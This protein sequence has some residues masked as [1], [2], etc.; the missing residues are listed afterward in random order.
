MTYILII[1]YS[2]K[3]IFFMIKICNLFMLTKTFF[4]TKKSNIIKYNI[5]TYII[6]SDILFLDTT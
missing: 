5:L 1:K 6:N 2:K 3:L 4:I